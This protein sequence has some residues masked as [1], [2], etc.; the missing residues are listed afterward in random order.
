MVAVHKFNEKHTN[1]NFNNAMYFFHV[2][3]LN[4]PLAVS[5]PVGV[6]LDQAVLICG[7]LARRED[8]DKSR[9]R[10]LFTYVFVSSCVPVGLKF[11]SQ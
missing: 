4:F 6:V 7:G 11:Q 2:T 9:T 3:A 5:R 8:G 1:L 10:V